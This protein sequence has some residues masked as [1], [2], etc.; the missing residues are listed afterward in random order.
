MIS[1]DS[2]LRPAPAATSALRRFARDRSGNI[3]MMFS[4]IILVMF[5]AIGM[6]VDYG[7]A[8]HQQTRLQT[9]AD[10][11]ALALAKDVE[12]GKTN[13]QIDAHKT[14]LIELNIDT[15]NLENWNAE[16]S[17][18]AT[19]NTLT[20]DITA[21][22]PTSFMSIFNVAE[23]DIGASATVTS[24]TDYVEIAMV[25]DNTGSMNSSN[26]LSELKTAATT[27]L[28]NLAASPAGTAG[29]TSVAVIP[30]GVSVN[31]G[32]T[33]KSADWLG[34]EQTGE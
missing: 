15:D 26:K 20:V 11:T 14:A 23:V 33:Y 18:D 2:F 4:L 27:M 28:T 8:Y 25:L 34:P 12:A 9:A 19:A 24:G 16:W 3:A 5:S 31:V 22:L 1:F 17:R 13:D 7:R 32:T 29:R 10:M 6:A 30:F 21:A